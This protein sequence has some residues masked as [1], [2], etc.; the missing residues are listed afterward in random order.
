MEKAIIKMRDT[1]S[2]GGPDDAGIYIDKKYGV[3]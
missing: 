3:G 1:L 2:H